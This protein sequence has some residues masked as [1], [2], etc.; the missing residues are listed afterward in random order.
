MP[1]PTRRQFAFSLSASL[2]AGQSRRRPNVVFILTDDQ[3]ADTVRAWGNPAIQTPN[4][5]ALVRSG[6][7]FTNAYCMGGHVGAVCLPSRM[8]I[9]RGVS[10]FRAIREQKPLP[11][12]ASTFNDGGYVTYSF[13]KKGNTD[14]AAQRSY[15][16]VEFPQPDDQADRYSGQPGKQM[17][18]RAIAFL[19]RWKS[20]VTLKQKP[21]FMYLAGA[22]PHDPRVAAPE[23]L[24][25]Y[26]EA[27]I[28]LP[29]NYQSFH[30]FN[31]GELKVRDEQLAP[32]PRT[33]EEIRQQLREYYAVVTQMDEHIGRVVKAVR[34]AGEAENT[35]FVF[36][37]DQGLAMGSHGLMGKQNLYEHSMRPS[38]LIAGPGIPKNRRVDDFAYLFDIFPTLCEL[39]GVPVPPSLEGRSLAPVLHGKGKGR[40]AIFLGYRDLQ[41]AVRR[42]PWK[43]I[44]YPKINRQQLFNLEHDPDEVNDLSAQPGQAERLREL[45]LLMAEQQKVW[46]DTAPL[47]SEQPQ[48]ADVTLDFFK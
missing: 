24:S 2:A 21:L 1:S 3:R 10:W 6:V 30:T 29:R 9:Q 28:R 36:T 32:W 12:L 44:V 8:M 11:N 48:A 42:G 7:T 38:L 35:Y 37:S 14:Q 43:L 4:L 40:E 15:Q 41:R 25:R 17:A 39:T 26:N 23:Y 47:Q 45:R 20:D 27:K 33:P 19:K 46:G 34:E 18:D 22:S 13:T 31:N 5:D 16:T